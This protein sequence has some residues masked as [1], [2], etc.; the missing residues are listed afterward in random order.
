MYNNVE[1]DVV[2]Q[3]ATGK[4]YER[5]SNKSS[6]FGV[7]VYADSKNSG[8]TVNANSAKG[9]GNG[10]TTTNANSHVTVGGTTYQNIGGDLVLDGAVVKGDHMSGQIDGAILAKSRPDTATYTGKQTNAGVSADI[11]FNGVPQSVSVNAGRSKVNAD[12][13][14]V[15]EQTG[16]ALNSSDVVVAKASRFDGAYFTTA[17]PE[18]NKTVFKEGVTTTDMQNHMN[19]KGDAINVGLGA[20][21][22]PEK[23]KVSPPGISGI[24]YGKDGDSQTSTTYGAV[25]GMAGKSDVTTANVSSLNETLENR[26]DKTAVEAQLGAQVQVSQAFDTERR[27]YR[28]EMAREQQKT[29]EE[30]KKHPV[31]S[32]EY[33]RLMDE[34]NKQQEKMVLFDSITGAIY[35][36][37]SNGA[38]GYVARAV[39]PQVSY[40]VG[41]Y[42]KSTNGEGT[43]PHILAHGI[44]AAA[45][46]VATGNDPTTGALSAMGAE[47]AAPM[48]A[49]FL[50]GDKPI[51]ELTADEKATVSSITT[52]AGLGMGATTGDVGSAVSAQQAAQVAVEDNQL[53]NTVYSKLTPKEQ[54]VYEKLINNKITPKYVGDF[55][56]AYKKCGDSRSCKNDIEK[57][58]RAAS[59]QFGTIVLQMVAENKLSREDIS[60]LKVNIANVLMSEADKQAKN[61]PSGFYMQERNTWSTLGQATFNNDL[62]QA[63]SLA[64]YNELRNQGYSGQA[65]KNQLLKDELTQLVALGIAFDGHQFIYTG[66]K[67]GVAGKTLVGNSKTETIVNNNRN[68]QDPHPVIRTSVSGRYEPHEKI[69]AIAYGE[70]KHGGHMEFDATKQG[71]EGYFKTNAGERIPVSLKNL[72]NAGKPINVFR[73]IREN[74]T[75]IQKAANHPANHVDY[76]PPGT[77]NKTEIY[78]NSPQFSKAE[79]SNVYYSSEIN[80]QTGFR[81]ALGRATNFQSIYIQAKDGVVVIKNG[82]IQ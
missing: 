29:V 39:A 47:A 15:K 24:G 62:N 49:K 69:N 21:I 77:L 14:A 9:Y 33:D 81:N 56:D 74:A 82:K 36:P 46:S 55:V 4:G 80:P 11:G 13:A 34:A 38:T 26:F 51:S 20:G 18:D 60:T 12:Y 19:Y 48:V 76:L 43:A 79:I 70:F 44:L 66:N 16:I 54:R 42:F 63:L 40:Q 45:V 64:R 3:A 6:G 78:V 72:E 65:L 52:L 7:G 8:F 71:I 17:T 35:G 57:Q 25:T 67:L 23:Q 32:A 61:D 37:D 22:N 58:Y 10:E 2:Y 53:L 73:E 28:L 5:S 75:S 41:Q 1:G 31:G 27:T 68:V 59:E 30:A 50:F